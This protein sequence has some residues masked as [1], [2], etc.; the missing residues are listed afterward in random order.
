MLPF[1]DNG[2]DKDAIKIESFACLSAHISL[3]NGIVSLY[4]L[5]YSRFVHRSKRFRFAYLTNPQPSILKA[6]WL[7]TAS[8]FSSH[9][10]LSL[11]PYAQNSIAKNCREISLPTPIAQGRYDEFHFSFVKDL[12]GISKM[13]SP[14]S[15]K[16]D[17]C[18]LFLRTKRGFSFFSFV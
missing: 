12:S 3:Q 16:S 6:F 5:R 10:S 18:R 9:L 2:G 8:F 7:A 4:Y 11:R 17:D 1:L 13:V 14:L 15:H